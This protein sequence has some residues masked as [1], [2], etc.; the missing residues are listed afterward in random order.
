[1][2]SVKV[3]CSNFFVYILCWARDVSSCKVLFYK[4]ESSRFETRFLFSALP[5]V[6]LRSRV[7]LK[8]LARCS[9]WSKVDPCT[10]FKIGIGFIWHWAST[11]VSGFMQ[12]THK[13]WFPGRTQLNTI[14]IMSLTSTQIVIKKGKMLVR[15]WYLYN[16][17]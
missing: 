15:K 10:H 11:Y 9:I 3:I 6:G 7:G 8:L 4:E 17:M 14:F 12:S 1:M 5:A 16:L 2:L 13:I